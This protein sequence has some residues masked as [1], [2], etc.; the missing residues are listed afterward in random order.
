M[1]ENKTPELKVPS[2]EEVVKEFF[3]NIASVSEVD[4]AI[5]ETLRNL[6]KV[7]NLSK[8]SILDALKEMRESSTK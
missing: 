6:Y 4:P 1:T 7:V 2:G 5:A 8:Q 3:E